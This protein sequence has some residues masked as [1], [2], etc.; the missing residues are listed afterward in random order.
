MGKYADAGLV[1]YE[2]LANPDD[3]AR[4]VVDAWRQAVSQF[5]VQMRDEYV[6][7]I[8]SVASSVEATQRMAEKLTNFYTQRLI[9]VMPAIKGAVASAVTGHRMRRVRIL[10]EMRGR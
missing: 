3:S 2:A 5:G 1:K 6:S 8:T 9:P 7:G 4:K 10:R